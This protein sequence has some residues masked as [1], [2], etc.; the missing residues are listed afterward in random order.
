MRLTRKDLLDS[1]E[2]LR[3]LNEELTRNNEKLA[4]ERDDAIARAERA[5]GNR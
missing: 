3:T 1:V 4:R 5:E 2:R